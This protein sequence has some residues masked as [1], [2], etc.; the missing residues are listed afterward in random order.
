MFS[1]KFAYYLLTFV[2]DSDIN[3]IYTAFPNE[4]VNRRA[5]STKILKRKKNV[6]L[7]IS[8]FTLDNML[9]NNNRDHYPLKSGDNLYLFI[10]IFIYFYLFHIDGVIVI[11]K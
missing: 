4:Y 1:R 10:H 7:Y 9:G 2:V 6:S 5:T 8:K 11:Q 3:T